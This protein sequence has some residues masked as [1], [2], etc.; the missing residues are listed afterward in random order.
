MRLADDW[1]QVFELPCGVLCRNDGDL[2]FLLSDEENVRLPF[3]EKFIDCED[4]YRGVKRDV[5]MWCGN[6]MWKYDAIM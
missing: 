4:S 6:V 2:Y 3:W 5:K 1:K